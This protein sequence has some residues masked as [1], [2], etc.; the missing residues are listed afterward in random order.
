MDHADFK[1][2]DIDLFIE[3]KITLREALCGF[4]LNVEHLDGRKLLLTCPPGQVLSP[5]ESS[6]TVRSQL[7]EHHCTLALIFW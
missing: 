4:S 1:R 5:G 3:K 6:Y 2:E 7:F